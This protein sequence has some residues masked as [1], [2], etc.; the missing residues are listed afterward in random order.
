VKE[1][2]PSESPIVLLPKQSMSEI[3]ISNAE[4]ITTSRTVQYY[5]GRGGD[6]MTFL[7]SRPFANLPINKDIQRI[8][9]LTRNIVILTL[10]YTCVSADELIELTRLLKNRPRRA[11]VRNWI[12]FGIKISRISLQNRLYRELILWRTA[13]VERQ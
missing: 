7:A 3:A 2:V 6:K 1:T 4:V 8:S 5:A 13:S 9:S 12:Q 10:F 11:T